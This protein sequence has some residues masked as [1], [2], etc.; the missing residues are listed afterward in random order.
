M[1]M[2]ANRER[3]DSFSLKAYVDELKDLA[4]QDKNLLETYDVEVESKEDGWRSHRGMLKRYTCILCVCSTFHDVGQEARGIISSLSNLRSKL[5]SEFGQGS[6]PLSSHEEELGH[7]LRQTYA[8][9]AEPHF[10]GME[11]DI[12]LLVSSVKDERQSVAKIYEIG[13]LAKTTLA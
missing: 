1:L 6:S 8:H 9:E 5:E 11:K 4:F 3:H 10:V 13:D 12:E 2:E 7:L